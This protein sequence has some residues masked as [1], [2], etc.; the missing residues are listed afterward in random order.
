[1]NRELD[2]PILSEIPPGPGTRNQEV[3]PLQAS[4][5]PG[6]NN[7]RPGGKSDLRPGGKSAEPTELALL[8]DQHREGR[9]SPAGVELGELPSRAGT[10]QRGIAEHMK[11]LMG[12]R[13]AVGD[14]RPLP[15]ATSMAVDA[16]LAPDKGTASKAIR[17]LVRLGVVDHVGSLPPRGLPNGTKLYAPPDEGDS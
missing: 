2:E 9:L 13:R 7:S 15:Y 11:L 10:V 14:E 5:V 12:L 1:M 17:A 16:G 6:G 8:V 3:S 4:L